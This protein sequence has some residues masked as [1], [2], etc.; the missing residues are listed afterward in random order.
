MV[1]DFGAVVC[2]GLHGIVEGLGAAGPVM[3]EQPAMV[4]AAEAAGLDIA[5]GQIGPAMRTAP[6]EQA[7]NPV[8]ILVEHQVFAQ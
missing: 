8:E 7:I 3:V 5:V 1:V 6:V 2:L 4:V